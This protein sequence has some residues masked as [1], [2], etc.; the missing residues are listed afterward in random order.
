[1]CGVKKTSIFSQEILDKKRIHAGSCQE[2]NYE[3]YNNE[4]KEQVFT[5]NSKYKKKIQIASNI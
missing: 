4:R 2:K 1:M 5:S 3:T